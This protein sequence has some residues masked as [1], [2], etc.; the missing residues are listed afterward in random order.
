MKTKHL[1]RLFSFFTAAIFLASCSTYVDIAKRQFNTGYYVHVSGKKSVNEKNSF[2]QKN[3][4]QRLHHFASSEIKNPE[5]NKEEN[6]VIPTE[7]PATASVSHKP[8]SGKKNISQPRENFSREI[9]KQ[10]S[11]IENT[12]SKKQL[13]KAITS[14][15]G[16]DVNTLVL[17]ILC[18]FI[19][20]LAVYLKVGIGKQFWIDLIFYVLALGA[21][22]GYGY[23]GLAWLIAVIYAFVICFA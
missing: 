8:V 5:I 20:P 10:A 7:I 19:P 23:L 4:E 1:L 2:V 17:I 21:F 11:Q 9:K 16:G 12:F 18:L 13:I 22:G 6:K 15:R 3:S 14:R